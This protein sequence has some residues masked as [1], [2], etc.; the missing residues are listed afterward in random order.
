M[1][2]NWYLEFSYTS[3]KNPKFY[4]AGPEW[5]QAV[6]RALGTGQID[7]VT[8]HTIGKNYVRFEKWSAWTAGEP[9]DKALQLIQNYVD[10]VEFVR[11][12]DTANSFS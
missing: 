11:S 4:F 3:K 7:T 12:N 9:R 6:E 2:G 1:G 10:N 8:Y 5:N